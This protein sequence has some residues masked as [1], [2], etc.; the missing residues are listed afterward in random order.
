[1]YIDGSL[2]DVHGVQRVFYGHLAHE[3]FKRIHESYRVRS[4]GGTDELGNKFKPLAP[5]TI[6]GRKLSRDDKKNMRGLKRSEKKEFRESRDVLIMRVTDAIY[7]SLRPS[8]PGLRGYRPRKNQIFNVAKSKLEIGTEVEYARFHARSR[9]PIPS[10]VQKWVSESV[11]IA[12]KA[13]MEHV[14]ENV[15]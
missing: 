4:E 8:K 9:P 5:S 1:M 12:M 14:G 13:V 6:R 2:P 10:N 11:K 7:N 3:M 15:L